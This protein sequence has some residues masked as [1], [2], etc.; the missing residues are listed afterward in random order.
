VS[1]VGPRS[2]GQWD[3][4]GC[5]A[6]RRPV[7]SSWRWPRTTHQHHEQ[8]A[9][10]HDRRCPC[11][12]TSPAHAVAR[13]AAMARA[14]RRPGRPSSP[15]RWASSSSAR[16]IVLSDARPPGPKISSCAVIASTSDR[17]V[18]RPQRARHLHRRPTPIP[19]REE[20]RAGHHLGQASRQT[21][22]VGQLSR[23]HHHH[24]HPPRR[25]HR[26]RPT[27][28]DLQSLRPGQRGITDQC[29][30]AC[31]LHLKGVPS[32]GSCKTRQSAFSQVRGIFPWPTPQKPTIKARREYLGPDRRSWAP[33]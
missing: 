12:S 6:P 3:G 7:A 27:D 25:S 4:R 20:P 22:P 2:S 19:D 11:Q 28:L 14:N 9:D 23:Q 33:G 30:G 8:R 10:R 13:A 26:P 5:S 18:A 16:N 29:P 32:W 1:R 17:H 24:H 15:S 31:S 21:E